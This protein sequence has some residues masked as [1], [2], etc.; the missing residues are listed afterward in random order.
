M[1]EAS[2]T[3]LIIKYLERI[4]ESNL[5]LEKFLQKYKV[6]FSRAQYYR[7]KKCYERDGLQSLQDGRAGGNHRR[8]TS[9]AATF[10]LGYHAANPYA[11]LAN[12]QAALKNQIG[13]RVDLA[14]ISRFFNARHGGLA[15]PKPPQVETFEVACGGLEIIAALAWHLKW[16][17]YT[18]RQIQR[19]ISSWQHQQG[20]RLNARQTA[21]WRGRDAQGHFTARYNQRRDIRQ[22][23]F[24]AIADKRHN[25]D[26]SRLQ[27]CASGFDTLARKALAVLALP[28]VTLNGT[29]RSVNTPLGNA[30]KDFAGYNYMD[31]TLDKFFRELKYLGIAESLVRNQIAFWQNHWRAAGLNSQNEHGPF[32]CYYIDGHTKALWSSK[33]VHKNKVTML[34]RVMGCLEQVFVHDGLGRPTY[35]ETYSGRA[36]WG[37]YV[38]SLFEKVEKKLEEPKPKMQVIR[39]LVLDGANNSVKTLRA[40]AAQDKYYFVTT[41]DKNQWQPR[42]IRAEGP[43][44]RYE[45]GE[46]FVS[47]CEIELEDSSDKGYLIVVRAIKIAW[48]DGKITVLI[49]NL[50]AKILDGS[51][52][53][54]T[55]FDRWPL[56]ELWFRDAKNFGALHR[57]AGY[58]KKLLDDETVRAK[59]KNLQK[60]IAVIRDQLQQPLTELSELDQ[61]LHTWI[62]KERQLRVRSRIIDGQRQMNPR[63][64][65]KLDD[66]RRAIAAL[67][68]QK[69]KIRQPYQKLFGRLK[70]HE[71]EWL[72]LQGK[73]KAYKVDVELDQILTYFRVAFV[74]LC[75]YFQMKFFSDASFSKTLTLASLLHRIFLL[76]ATIEQ[77]KEQRRIY[78]KRNR[79]DKATMALLEQVLPKLNQ[80]NLRHTSGR[81]LEFFLK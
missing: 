49:T 63:Q 28:V 45:Y 27:L 53:A 26:L 38:L 8:L 15:T 62:E 19:A 75:A 48:D 33:R 20:Q 14:T 23:R 47:D 1:N 32:L 55:Y 12:Y 13:V 78:L 21:D 22:T 37:E 29:L 52:V 46:A 40:F 60:K 51:R 81:R 66:C 25:K 24:A 18:A 7:Y 16:P 31:A 3:R 67:G 76:P 17:E 2:R 5:S 68:R 30:L 73:E 74:N 61:Q 80:L 58:G 71:Q 57:V 77:T 64:A 44:R 9:E 43:K 79:K 56:Q 10:L 65:E 59:Q 36:P 69:R 54:K 70:H 6:P 35:F 39:L 72:R 4:D 50:P 11:K 34:G 41:L 42:R